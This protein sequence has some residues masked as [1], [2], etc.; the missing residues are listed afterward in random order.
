MELL[1][2]NEEFY[3][4]KLIEN[5]ETF[6]WTER[7]STPGDFQLTFNDIARAM[8][9]LPEGSY[10]TLRESTVPMKVETHKIE[11]KK[12]SAPVL[13]ITGRSCEACWLELRQSVKTLPSSGPRAAWTL[14]AEKE[15]D[16]AYKIIRTI[17]GDVERF[18]DEV[19]VLD[20]IAPAV[21]PLDAIPEINLTIPQDYDT[22]VTNNYQVKAGNLYTTIMELIT[23]N[24]HGIKSVRPF[25][26]NTQVDIEIYNG[27]DQ[28]ELIVFDARFDQIDDA[29]YLLSRLG[30][31]N[32]GYVYSD[33]GSQKV[34]KTAAEEPAGLDRR[35][36]LV[37]GSGATIDTRKNHG[38]VELYTHNATA[39]FD[40][41]VAEQVADGYNR[42]YFLGDILKLVGQYGLSQNVRV[43]EFIRS[44]DNSGEKA[45]PTFE[46][47]VD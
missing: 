17:I 27:A 10:V 16:A 1:T 5:Y 19:S 13:T 18:Q 8:Q 15:S 37:E 39:L 41:Q 29:T 45:Y 47:I 25:G 34:L 43:S 20:V 4:D 6:I 32:V 24:H 35:V 36:L 33:S 44:S 12:N 21:D 7:Y 3:P 9:L 30:E 22:G 28:T 42:S 2:L 14:Q 11:K 46:A 23:T 40:G 26:G 31:T 38:L